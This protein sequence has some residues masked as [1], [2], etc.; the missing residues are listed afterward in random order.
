MNY[1]TS[2]Q[3]FQDLKSKL[4]NAEKSLVLAK[5]ELT[6]AR[7]LT[8]NLYDQ[9]TTAKAEC[10]VG[11]VGKEAVSDA[12]TAYEN[13]IDR[14]DEL[15]TELKTKEKTINLYRQKV[16]EARSQY[17]KSA[18]SHY[19]KKSLPVIEQFQKAFEELDAARQSHD[20]L[21]TEMK[22]NEVD[23]SIYLPGEIIEIEFKINHLRQPMTSAQW[24]KEAAEKNDQFKPKN[25]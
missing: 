25:K 13:A 8:P 4:L 23:S 22:K 18:Y 24:I 6:K 19:Q 12:E 9:L 10:E 15:K 7:Q 11:D 2:L 16:N 20:K 5:N 17:L 21:L 1:E 3:N 14:L